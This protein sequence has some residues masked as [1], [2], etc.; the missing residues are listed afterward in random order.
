MKLNYTT[1]NGRI[2]VELEGKTQTEIFEQLAEFQE[3]FESTECVVG[4]KRSD[5]VRFVVR[6]DKDEN[7]YYELR[8]IDKDKD[9]QYRKLAFGQNKKGGTLFPKRKD[10]E[11]NYLKNSGWVLF[12]KE[13]GKEE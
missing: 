11:G 1:K 13:T 9:L 3:V 5:D 6:T 4:E 8:C 2:S 12:N 7:K 10:A